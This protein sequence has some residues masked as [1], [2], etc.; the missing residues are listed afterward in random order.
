M[1]R[2]TVVR[3]MGS[4]LAIALVACGSGSG[5]DTGG[6]SGAD[7]IGAC[8]AGVAGDVGRRCSLSMPVQGG[9]T[10]TLDGKT[11][12]GDA[13]GTGAG[14][15]LSWDSSVLGGRVSANFANGLPDQPGTFP[16]TSLVIRA[17]GA[18]GGA[19]SWT[20]PSGACTLTVTSV[21]VECQAV[22]RQLMRV[23]TGTGTCS[24]PAAPDAGSSAAPI[25]I[26]DFQVVHWL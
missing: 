5:T 26:G 8:D 19:E 18:D 3:A 21:D 25:T 23:V 12:C 13:S 16:L 7:A 9:L 2:G 20:A 10:G 14:D 24:Q 4:I 15:F 22:F 11:G 6:D 17:P 1:R